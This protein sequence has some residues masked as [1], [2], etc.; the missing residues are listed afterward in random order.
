[1]RF[2]LLSKCPQMRRILVG[3]GMLV[4]LAPSTAV[5]GKSYGGFTDR[6]LS[7]IHPPEMI[8]D[9]SL[10]YFDLPVCPATQVGLVVLHQLNACN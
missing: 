2:H 10:I 9:Q 5:C 3:E 8:F 4:S 1:M 6:Y 7:C